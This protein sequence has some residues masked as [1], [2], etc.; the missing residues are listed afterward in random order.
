MLELENHEIS[1]NLMRQEMLAHHE[2]QQARDGKISELNVMVQTLMRQVKRKGK[3]SD[4]MP[5]AMGA[6]GG[7]PA[8]PPR[9]RAAGAPGGGGGGD[10]D[11]EGEGSGRRPEES[12]KGR[13]AERPPLP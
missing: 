2:A 9:R 4:P 8:P 5:E 10:S 7:K 1:L 11:D 12:R 6:G 13:R 3:A